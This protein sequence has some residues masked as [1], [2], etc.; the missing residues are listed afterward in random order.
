MYE[1]KW[2]DPLIQNLTHVFAS[3]SLVLNQIG[4]EAQV[5][6]TFDLNEFRFKENASNRQRTLNNKINL[7]DLNDIMVK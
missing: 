2:S 4:Y 7:N 1:E 6:I 5:P 3:N